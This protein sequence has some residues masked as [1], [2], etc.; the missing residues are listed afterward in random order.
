MSLILD[1]VPNEDYTLGRISFDSNIIVDI[2][3]TNSY[4]FNF[5]LSLYL[6]GSRYYIKGPRCLNDETTC[7]RRGGERPL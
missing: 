7:G 2:I 5:S 1:R 3:A 4:I 6:S